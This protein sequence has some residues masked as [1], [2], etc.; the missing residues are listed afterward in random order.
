MTVYQE[1][2]QFANNV[3]LPLNEH[4]TFNLFDK[5]SLQLNARTELP[6]DRN[7]IITSYFNWLVDNFESPLWSWYDSAKQNLPTCTF[8]RFIDLVAVMLAVGRLAL[9]EENEDS[10]NSDWS[11]DDCP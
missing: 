2:E 8:A 3:Q 5:L 1:L 6:H 4:A 7:V 9:L 10:D 11:G